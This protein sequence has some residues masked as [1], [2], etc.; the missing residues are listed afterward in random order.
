MVRRRLEHGAEACVE[1]GMACAMSFTTAV[2]VQLCFFHLTQIAT[3]ALE[4]GRAELDGS[5]QLYANS[6]SE[7]ISRRRTIGLMR[8]LDTTACARA[9]CP[10]VAKIYTRE[11]CLI[12]CKKRRVQ[13]NRTARPPEASACART[14]ASEMYSE[15]I[16]EQDRS[17]PSD[18]GHHDE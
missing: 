7:A 12:H 18:L 11:G 17:Q 1:H 6:T 14:G 8:A 3:F 5:Y 15:L 2:L 9:Y 16:W 13:E 10:R 4:H